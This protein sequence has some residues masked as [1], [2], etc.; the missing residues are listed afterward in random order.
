MFKTYVITSNGVQC[1]IY[2]REVDAEIYINLL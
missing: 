2:K 1:T